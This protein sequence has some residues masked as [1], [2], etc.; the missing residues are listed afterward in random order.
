M[1]REGDHDGVEGAVVGNGAQRGGGTVEVGARPRRGGRR[2]TRASS[3]AVDGRGQSRAVADDRTRCD[4]AVPEGL[5]GAGSSKIDPK[6]GLDPP[7]VACAASALTKARGMTACKTASREATPSVRTTSSRRGRST[8]P[9]SEP[10]GEEHLARAPPEIVA[11]EVGAERAEVLGSRDRVEREPTPAAGSSRGAG[12]FQC[13]G[14]HA[15]VGDRRH[16]VDRHAR[17]GLATELPGERRHGPLG[18]AV[19]AG[20]G[21][22]P[23]RAGRD[24]HNVAV[25]RSGHE[26]QCGLEHVEVAPEV[27]VEQCEPVFLGAL[28]E[29]GLPGDA[30]HVHDGVEALVLVR[31]L[32]EQVVQRR[33]V[34]DRR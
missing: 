25:P 23:S 3:A 34:G 10:A 5:G 26:R 33:A 11:D 30:G 19:P 9:T 16:R 15:G 32:L 12:P 29:I 24:A 8:T 27:H 13:R 18:G 17:R 6:R 7:S 1:S 2:S 31:Q 21:R 14:D 22:P 4:G 28:G 20:V